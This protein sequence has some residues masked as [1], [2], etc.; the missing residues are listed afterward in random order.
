M[1]PRRPVGPQ[2]FDELMQRVRRFRPSD[3]LPAIAHRSAEL[4]QVK[5]GLIPAARGSRHAREFMLAGVAQLSV[6]W[7]NE[8][9]DVHTF[10]VD[11]LDLLL[12]I[13]FNLDDPAMHEAP[14]DSRLLGLLSRTLYEQGH[15]QSSPIDSVARM[16]RV[17]EAH[18]GREPK[19]PTPAEWKAL[20]GVSIKHFA[21]ISLGLHKTLI[22]FH[23]TIGIDHL[24]LP[25]VVRQFAP[26]D[27]SDVV[28]VMDTWF[29]SNRAGHRSW[30]D[31]LPAN[32]KA[33]LRGSTYSRWSP[34]ALQAAPIV[35]LDSKLVS[36]VTR[37]VIDRAGT[38]GLYFIGLGKW[39]GRFTDSLGTLFEGYVEEQLKI[40]GQPTTVVPEIEYERGKKSVDFFVVTPAV[41]ILVE[42][43]ANRP[44]W[45]A[46]IGSNEGFL[47]FEKK[48]G[49]AKDQIMNTSHLIDAR[50]PALAHL[51][52]DIPR[53]GLIV[54]LE[55]FYGL[56]TTAYELTFDQTP[57]PIA[58]S[59]AAE[60]EDVVATLAD[61][62]D[63]GSR[64]LSALTPASAGTFPDLT[65]ALEGL[66]R[67]SNT[68]IDRE[69]K[70]IDES[71]MVD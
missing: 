24:R 17:L 1:P 67:L 71:D 41:L 55:A 47:D 61:R 52:H 64:L 68:I 46:R 10:T 13:Y 50:H 60:L 63:V 15:F 27:V 34:H 7:A 3:L 28:A 25:K 45:E 42:V 21:R 66:S 33:K 58:I 5:L 30:F 19:A 14:G 31:G 57:F 39:R 53:R 65:R 8:F 22:A 51:P 44:I 48:I 37:Y 35:R 29:T 59:S 2:R 49:H 70:R 9:R 36:P 56:Q 23:G 6:L 20:L 43:K 18:H 54:T 40:L 16:L 4:E 69:C 38:S 32:V 26:L 62:A 11:D 12:Q